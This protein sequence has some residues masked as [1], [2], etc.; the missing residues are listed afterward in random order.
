[1]ALGGQ[2]DEVSDCVLDSTVLIFANIVWSLT[3]E[4]PIVDPNF[5]QAKDSHV[6]AMD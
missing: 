5:W 2:P 4:Q 6:I 1:M 3:V